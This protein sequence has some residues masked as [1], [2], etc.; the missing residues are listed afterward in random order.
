MGIRIWIIRQ[1]AYLTGAVVA[2]RMEFWGEKEGRWDE[3]DPRFSRNAE[4]LENISNGRDSSQVSDSR[5]SP[6]L[7]ASVLIESPHCDKPSGG[8]FVSLRA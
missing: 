8:T 4:R 7:P 5:L 1:G 6:L 3:M 2:T